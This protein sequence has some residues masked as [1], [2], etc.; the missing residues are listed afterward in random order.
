M[1]I[2]RYFPNLCGVSWYEIAN[3]LSTGKQ[4]EHQNETFK[5]QRFENN[6]FQLLQLHHNIVNAIEKP[7]LETAIRGRV[8]L[9]RLYGEFVKACDNECQKT[10]NA[11]QIKIIERSFLAFFDKNEPELGLYF[12]NL[13]NIFKFIDSSD[14]DDKTFYTNLVRAQLSLPELLLLFYDALTPLGNEKFKPLIEKYTLFKNIPTDKLVSG[15][16]NYS[17]RHE[18]LYAESAF[19]KNA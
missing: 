18:K 17:F 12:R 11:G 3:R 7:V 14:I 16:H 2:G 5:K 19:Q 15:I 8:V 10:P 1:G 4:L 9:K 13:Y 6:F